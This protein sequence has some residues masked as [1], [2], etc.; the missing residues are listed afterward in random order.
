MGSEQSVGL[1][2][3][4]RVVVLHGDLDVAEAV[5]LEERCLPQRGLDQSLGRRLAVLLEQSL[6]E[7][8]G[9][10]ADADRRTHVLGGARDLLDLVVELLDVAGIDAHARAARLES[11]KDV[12]RLEVDIGDDRD[13]GLAGDLGQGVGVVLAG[14][15]DT[16]DL[17]ARRG[18][19]GDL[20][21]GGVDIGR[22]RGRHRLHAH[23]RIAPDLDRVRGVAQQ[24]LTRGAPRGQ[25]GRRRGRQSEVDAHPVSIP[26]PGVFDIPASST[27]R[28]Q[29]RVRGLTRSAKITIAPTA[30]RAMATT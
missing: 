6:V 28:R 14:H 3:H 13:A 4:D 22:Q 15:C 17:A 7:R 2:H 27:S 30:T 19:L 1:H 18:E 23:G 21:Q 29:P 16:H 20:L 12:L 8:S 5:L 11:G 25:G 9:V 10:D 26:D 24:E